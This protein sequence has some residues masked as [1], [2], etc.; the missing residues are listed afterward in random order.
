MVADLILF[1]VYINWPLWLCFRVNILLNFLHNNEI[2]RDNL[3]AYK[4]LLN[5]RT[6]MNKVYAW[7]LFFLV[8]TEFSWRCTIVGFFKA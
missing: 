7:V 5:Q 3:Y 4:R 2:I 6:F 8:F 1:C